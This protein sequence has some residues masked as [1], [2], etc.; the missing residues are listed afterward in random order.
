MNQQD[1]DVNEAQ[2]SR[3]LHY[4]LSNGRCRPA[5]VV[6][7]YTKEPVPPGF[8]NLKVFLDV[9]DVRTDNEL[10]RLIVGV[11]PNHASKEPGSWHWPRECT[12][13]KEA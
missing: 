8:V 4:V 7:S 11:L 6:H 1:Q 5:L 13:T 10:E 3:L 9:S 2:V 12:H